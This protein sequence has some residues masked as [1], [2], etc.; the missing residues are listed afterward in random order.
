MLPPNLPS[1]VLSCPSSCWGGGLQRPPKPDVCPCATAAS[2][3]Q[4][5]HCGCAPLTECWQLIRLHLHQLRRYARRAVTLNQC[6]VVARRIRLRVHL[7]PFWSD[8]NLYAY[9]PMEWG[10]ILWQI[11]APFWLVPTTVSFGRENPSVHPIKQKLLNTVKC[12]IVT[13]G[14]DFTAAPLATGVRTR[15]NLGGSTWSPG[16]S[17]EAICWLRGMGVILQIIKQSNKITASN[18]F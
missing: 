8:F 9:A 2:R 10:I 6:R 7:T 16:R 13:A 15:A 4:A 12:F 14:V 11:R 1:P 3:L 18:W 17:Q 5:S